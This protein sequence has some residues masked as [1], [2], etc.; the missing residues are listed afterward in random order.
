MR[1]RL[2]H[3]ME[4]SKRAQI[5]LKT[6]DQLRQGYGISLLKSASQF[7]A[8]LQQLLTSAK[9]SSMQSRSLQ[10]LHAIKNVADDIF[11]TF[12]ETQILQNEEKA[13]VDLICV[14]STLLF[15]AS[16]PGTSPTLTNSGISTTASTLLNSD[17]RDILC[18]VIV[19]LQLTQVYFNFNSLK[20]NENFSFRYVDWHKH[21]T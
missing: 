21:M 14:L 11:F 2:D 10:L 20:R 1:L 15:N 18:H 12:Y 7:V 9:T 6:N 4:A 19:T 3:R 13:L 5:M 16:P 8:E 17:C